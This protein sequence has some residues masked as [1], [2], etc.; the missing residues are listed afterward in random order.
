MVSAV[1]WTRSRKQLAIRF[2]TARKVIT[3]ASC[4]ISRP[5]MWASMFRTAAAA[6]ESRS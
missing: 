1:V 6:E 2:S 3:S 5:G 4:S